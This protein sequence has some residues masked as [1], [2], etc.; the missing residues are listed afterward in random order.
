MLVR[1]AMPMRTVPSVPPT[2][3][4]YPVDPL[5]A[6]ETTAFVRMAMRVF[7]ETLDDAGVAHLAEVELADP[8]L[9][10]AARDAGRIVGTTTVLDFHMTVPGATAV[11]C[12]GV[13]TVAVMPTHR[14]RGVLTSLMRR[15]LDD[16][17]AGGH[18][19]AALYASESGIYGRYGYG[20]ATSSLQ[21]RIDRAWTRLRAP[22]AP[23]VVDMLTPDE[24]LERVPAIYRAVAHD[25]PGMMTVSD[26]MWR[27]QLAW[28]PTDGRGG[29]S[30]RFIVTVDDRA[31]A[32]YRIDDRWNDTGSDAT[33]RV[34]RCM[35]VDVEAHRQ[36]WTFLFGIDL[37]Q[38]VDIRRLPVDH[39]L[40]WWLAER[41][42]LRLTMADPLYVRLIDVGSALSQRGTTTDAGVV[43]DVTDPF[44]PW[45]TRRWTLEGDGSGLHCEPTSA[46]A[47]LW[48]DVR[49][50]AG[51]SLG[52]H[53]AGELS[54]AGMVH[55]TTPGA[56]ERLTALLASPRPPYNA[57]V[58]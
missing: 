43:L 52:G 19:W 34:E 21:G 26:A 41:R 29:A 14:R 46:P 11:P 56:L 24:A 5:T 40:P 17:H 6:D 50:L 33:L 1:P 12:A 53:T 36:L 18:A 51:M 55:E 20:P 47:D 54:R 30:E 23:G 27:D 4:P 10:L 28:D 8:S 45:N 42:R 2:T 32:T 31:Y 39:P 48:L 35:A 9:S 16:L 58:F 38:H 37:V 44:C 13:T 49:E 25:L 15:Q 3:P 22:V 57:F 7:G